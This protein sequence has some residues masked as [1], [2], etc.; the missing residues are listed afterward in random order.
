MVLLLS[1]VGLSNVTW[2]KSLMGIIGEAFMFS[3]GGPVPYP[4]DGDEVV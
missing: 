4:V 3:D 2:K 1:N